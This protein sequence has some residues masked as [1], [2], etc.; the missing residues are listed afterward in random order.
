MPSDLRHLERGNFYFLIKKLI[1]GLFFLIRQKWNS[2]IF[3]NPPREPKDFDNR[4]LSTLKQI[5]AHHRIVVSHP[6]SLSESFKPEAILN[7]L[8]FPDRSVTSKQMMAFTLSRALNSIPESD[9]PQKILYKIEKC[10]MSRRQQ[11]IYSDLLNQSSNDLDSQDIDRVMTAVNKLLRVCNHVDFRDRTLSDRQIF[12]DPIDQN[13]P[14]PKLIRNMV[15]K[16][17]EEW[18]YEVIES[19]QK[20]L[21]WVVEKQ[22]K[23]PK[24]RYLTELQKTQNR[25]IALANSQKIENIEVKTEPDCHVTPQQNHPIEENPKIEINDIKMEIDST[26]TERSLKKTSF[27]NTRF[28]DTVCFNTVDRLTIS[29]DQNRGKRKGSMAFHDRIRE[30]NQQKYPWATSSTINALSNVMECSSKIKQK[31][32]SQNVCRIKPKILLRKRSHDS[33]D[34]LINEENI[35]RP[36]SSKLEQMRKELNLTFYRSKVDPIRTMICVRSDECGE[37]IRSYL[38]RSLRIDSVFLHSKINDEQKLQ[39]VHEFNFSQSIQARVK[40]KKCF[41]CTFSAVLNQTCFIRVSF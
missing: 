24:Q 40:N 26:N 39:L 6:R 13:V 34:I 19:I 25:L 1:I 38:L 30:K 7:P 15:S 17:E 12:L 31:C 29:F 36:Y 16:I 32:K 41:N 18:F 4:A 37:L 23:N 2:L 5:R 20:G 3:D 8:L 22:R 27:E 35:I 14:Y 9:R 11:L 28:D 10:A 21:S 33:N